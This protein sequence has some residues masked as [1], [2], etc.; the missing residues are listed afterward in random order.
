M[1]TIDQKIERFLWLGSE[2]GYQERVEK[3]QQHADKAKKVIDNTQAIATGA[4]DIVSWLINNWQLAVLG[5][6]A[7]LVLL[8]D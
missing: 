6:I 5:L 7:L 8:R 3:N 4:F 1:A 2:K